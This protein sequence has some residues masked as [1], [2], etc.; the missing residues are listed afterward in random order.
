MR[1][2]GIHIAKSALLAIIEEWFEGNNIGKPA[3]NLVEHVYKRSINYTLTHRKKLDSYTSST[4]KKTDR[5]KMSTIDAARTFTGLLTLLR[6]QRKHR[7]ITRVR[8]GGKDWELIK[9]CTS[10]AVSFCEAFDLEERA[11]F[12]SYINIFLDLIASD[13]GYF[14]LSAL[15]RKHDLI[16]NTHLVMETI[17]TDPNKEDTEEIHRIYSRTIAEKTGMDFNYDREP[18]KYVYFVYAAELAKTMKMK[19]KNY[20][21]AQ[22][23]GLA[24]T[25]N[26]PT[27]QQMVTKA[28]EERAMRYMVE[29]NLK[30][31]TDRLDPNDMS[32]DQVKAFWAKLKS[33]ENNLNQ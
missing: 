24:W 25:K 15:P 10:K 12:T 28:A 8:E 29:N 22:F 1:D 21:A 33:H 32:K 20:I 7:G 19:A 31:T 14:N 4:K 6:T 9:E 17:V 18:M 26:I 13:R 23:E 3:N 27:P 11:G 5:L 30:V 2:P 16:V